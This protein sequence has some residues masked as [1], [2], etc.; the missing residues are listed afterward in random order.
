MKGTLKLMLV[1]GGLVLG[2][3]GLTNTEVSA[4]SHTNDYQI[5]ATKFLRNNLYTYNNHGSFHV[6][7]QYKNKNVYVWNKSHTKVLYNMKDFPNSTLSVIIRQT[8]AHKNKRSVYYAAFIDTPK[9]KSSAYGRIWRGYLANG[10]NRNYKVWNY[11]S[12]VGFTNDQDYL[13]YIHQSPSQAVTRAVLKLFP[14]SKLSLEL[15]SLGQFNSDAGAGADSSVFDKDFK[16]R[17]NLRKVATYLGPST[18]PKEPNLTTQQ[19]ITKIKQTLTKEGFT[20]SKRQAM[21]DY[22]IGVYMPNPNAGWEVAMWSLN[23]AKPRQ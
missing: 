7:S 1:I 23:L 6:K 21:G 12:T 13:N 14:N 9:G 2:L 16:D 10:Y 20:A 18:E 22:V 3:V 4:K 19:R 5:V 8:Y 17:L 11:L 15:S